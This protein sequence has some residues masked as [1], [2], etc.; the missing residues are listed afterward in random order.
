MIKIPIKKDDKAAEYTYK[1]VLHI[2]VN[3]EDFFVCEIF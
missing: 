3:V 2:S 1:K